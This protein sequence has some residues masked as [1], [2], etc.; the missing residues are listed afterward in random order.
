MLLPAGTAW[1]KSTG[2]GASDRK[3]IEAIKMAIRLGYY[4]IDAAEVYNT[5]AEVG[6][7]IRESKIEREKLF[8]TTKVMTNIAD[9]PRA[10]DES[11]TKLQTDYVDL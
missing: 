8:V 2:S 4:H 7:A 1:F 5:E 9:I 10:I 3:T 6:T 11:L